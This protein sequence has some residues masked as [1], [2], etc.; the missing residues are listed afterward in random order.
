MGDREGDRFVA[1]CPGSPRIGRRSQPAGLRDELPCDQ[2]PAR[3]TPRASSCRGG[4]WCDS[5][6]LVVRKDGRGLRGDQRGTGDSVCR[7][8]VCRPQHDRWRNAA[9]CRWH[10]HGDCP[11]PT[12]PRAVVAE[13]ICGVDSGD[14][15]V[16][17]GPVGDQPS[18]CV[19]G[20]EVRVGVGWAGAV[21]Q[22]R[23]LVGQ[24]GHRFSVYRAN[25][26][27]QPD[28]GDRVPQARHLV[29][30]VRDG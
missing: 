4:R 22:Q 16:F 11:F 3:F 26:R 21:G 6:G 14:R 17:P 25:D 12:F 18:G 7:S 30:G 29:V 19:G 9:Q 15:D 24:A 20:A 28:R 13:C 5:I 1:A 23:L 27:V 8:P 10:L 2:R